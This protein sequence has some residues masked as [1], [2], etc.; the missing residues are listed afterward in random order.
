MEDAEHASRTPST[1][2]QMRVYISNGS[3]EQDSSIT[4]MCG[5]N[6]VNPAGPWLPASRVHTHASSLHISYSCWAWRKWSTPQYWWCIFKVASLMLIYYWQ[7]LCSILIRFTCVSSCFFRCTV[8]SYNHRMVSVKC[9]ASML[10]V[11]CIGWRW[12]AGPNM[13]V[14]CRNLLHGCCF[15][16]LGILV[17]LHDW[18]WE[19]SYYGL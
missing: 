5:S 7:L 15:M 8:S 9:P 1:M 3:V 10:I 13:I 4:V 14:L 19:F 2:A 11:T 16:Q 12:S 6:L 18:E 17:C